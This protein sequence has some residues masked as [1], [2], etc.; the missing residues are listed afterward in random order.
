MQRYSLVL[1]II[2]NIILITITIIL[3]QSNNL[4]YKNTLYIDKQRLDDIK[5]LEKIID[6]KVSKQETIRILESNFNKGDFF[7]KNEEN[8]IGI[9]N[10]FLIF[11]ENNLLS[12]I[13]SNSF[14][15]S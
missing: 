10:I 3:N 9:G 4:S 5:I 13:E 8:G 6:G 7:Y 11:D 15:G 2:L 12:K 14:E 1:S